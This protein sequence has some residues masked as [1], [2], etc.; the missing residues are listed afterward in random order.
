DADLYLM[1][2][3]AFDPN[4]GLF[5]QRDPS[6]YEDSVN[7]YAGFDNDPI[8]LRDPT[9]EVAWTAAL[10]YLG[11]RAAESA[12]ETG[13]EGGIAYATG[14]Q[15]FSWT[16][17]FLKNFAVNSAIG[18]IPGATELKISTRA[19]ALYS[20]KLALR[21]VGDAVLDT[22]V[23][24]GSFSENLARAAVANLA[25]DTLGVTLQRVVGRF[26]RLGT[27]SRQAARPRTRRHVEGVAEFADDAL[28]AHPEWTPPSGVGRL[29]VQSNGVLVR[30]FDVTAPD[31][32][33]FHARIFGD[34]L[35]GD[36]IAVAKAAQ[37]KGVSTQLM[38]MVV[39]EAERVLG[40]KIKRIEGQAAFDNETLLDALDKTGI[41]QTPFAKSAAHLGF[42]NAAAWW[43][44]AEKI[45][46]MSVSRPQP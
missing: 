11:K 13:I 44:R 21:S 4:T 42:T 20:G 10:L 2:A 30:A 38:G 27:R 45:W 14:D 25:G 28:R 5:L 26:P 9:G 29:V 6:G 12:V 37:G 46:M 1:K 7:L 16:W 40:R 19:A 33:F 18:V 36:M 8:N 24:G 23:R 39:E 31:E 41:S 22:A 32:T 43:D 3:R 34:T 35:W 17:T 15:Q